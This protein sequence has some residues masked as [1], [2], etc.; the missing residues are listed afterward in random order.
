MWFLR[1]VRLLGRMDGIHGWDYDGV[2][3]GGLDEERRSSS[4]AILAKVS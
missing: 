2:R 3:L 1:W 4:S